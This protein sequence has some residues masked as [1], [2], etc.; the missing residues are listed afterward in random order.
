[1]NVPVLYELVSTIVNQ[2]P[3]EIR[4]RRV[5]RD[6]VLG[7]LVSRSC[8]LDDVAHALRPRGKVESQYRRLQRFL[9]NP[10]I[11]I[12]SV[13]QDWASMVIEKMRPENLVL[14]VDETSLSDHL[15]IMVLGIWT[16]DGCVPIAWRSYHPKAYPECGQV[17]L[18][19]DLVQRI[20]DTIPV[21]CSVIVL[22]DR[23]IGTSPDLIANLTQLGVDILFRV[24]DSTRFHN[25]EGKNISLG[26]L[27]IRGFVWQAPAQ[28]FKKAG[29]MSLYSTVAWD[30]IYDAP[31]CLVSSRPADPHLY[32]RRFDQEVS[33]RDLKSDGFQWHRS[34][35]WLPDHADRLLLVLAIAYWLV[36]LIGQ[37]LPTATRGRQSRLSCFR[38]GLDAITSHFRPTVAALLP[39]PPFPPPRI[40]CVVQ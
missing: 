13:Q 27:G 9:A 26:E 15:K 19:T 28:V 29:W 21:P 31:W 6:F 1:M 16:R 4:L 11:D 25:A 30:N 33:F 22:A 24:Q 38:R 37:S 36:M 8:L 7:T 3:L 20:V 2:F 34:H 35:V 14:L 10:Q 5:L 32:S 23:G 12:A 40:T 39:P 18:I 17:A